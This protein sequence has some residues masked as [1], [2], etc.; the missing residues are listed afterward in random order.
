M[1]VQ[2][3]AR[4]EVCGGSGVCDSFLARGSS[5]VCGSSFT[6]SSSLA[7]G[8]RL[9]CGRLWSGRLKP[10][11][12]SR[13]WREKFHLGGLRPGRLR[14]RLA[15][16]LRRALGGSRPFQLLHFQMK[17]HLD[18]PHGEH[19]EKD[20]QHQIEKMA[21]LQLF[22]LPLQID[23]QTSLHGNSP[24]DILMSVFMTNA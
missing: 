5:G 1:T 17:I 7:R 20:G 2:E 9:V 14:D 4:C 18:D 13:L 22:P 16:A 8:S 3:P 21:P 10:L 11:S 6:R 23:S 19:G 12:G 24:Y 15:A